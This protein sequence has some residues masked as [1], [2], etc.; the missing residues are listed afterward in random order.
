M[1]ILIDLQHSLLWLVY[2]TTPLLIMFSLM[3][4]VRSFTLTLINKVAGPKWQL[5][6][7][8]I[9]TPIHELSH[10]IMVWLTGHKVEK[11]SLFQPDP[12]S[13]TLG[14]VVHSY[15]KNHPLHVIGNFFIGIAPLLTGLFL[16]ML[17]TKYLHPEGEHILKINL[18]YSS[19]FESSWG[20]D[21]VP[22]FL[23]SIFSNQFEVVKITFALPMTSNFLIWLYIT[24]SVSLYMLP[25]KVDMHNSLIG[26]GLLLA[27][28]V[29][30]VTLGSSVAEVITLPPVLVEWHQWFTPYRYIQY[31]T[32]GLTAM[33]LVAIY[34]LLLSVL[35]IPVKIIS[36][37]MS[38]NRS[39]KSQTTAVT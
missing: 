21:T 28:I 16:I 37:G 14:Y 26:A 33:L 7:A 12:H 1:D 15:I 5:P 25:S 19:Q 10:M 18:A 30:W 11:Y 23:K 8:I 38:K 13:K 2:C 27:I 35:S 20:I 4:F 34:S 29:T 32:F 22:G 3:Y 6:F 24:S 36:V 39:N 9:G 31:V 17:L